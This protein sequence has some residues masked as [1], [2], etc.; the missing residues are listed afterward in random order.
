MARN[1]PDGLKARDF[2][3]RPWPRPG[4]AGMRVV[5]GIELDAMTEAQLD[6]LLTSGAEIVF[7]RSS[8]EA[9]LRIADALRAMGQVV[10]MTGDGVN[11]A[12]HCA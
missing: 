5:T 3:T 1:P 11:D 9:K 12:P 8:P 10:A 6:D 7:A 2:V 4:A